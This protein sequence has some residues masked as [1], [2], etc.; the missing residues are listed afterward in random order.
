MQQSSREKLPTW[1]IYLF[2]T[3]L[4]IVFAI[5]LLSIAWNSTLEKEESLVAAHLNEYNQDVFQNFNSVSNIAESLAVF[6][7][8]NPSIDDNQFEYITQNQI[9][10]YPFV[11]SVFYAGLSVTGSNTDITS[12]TIRHI[13][14]RDHAYLNMGDNLYQIREIDQAI[15]QQHQAGALSRFS[16]SFSSAFGAIYGLFVPVMSVSG[17]DNTSDNIAG[18]IGV[19]IQPDKIAAAIGKPEN[20]SVKIFS[21]NPVLGRQIL[22]ANDLTSSKGKFVVSSVSRVNQYQFPAATIRTEIIRYIKFSDLDK[23]LVYITLIIGA[24]ITLLL[25]ALVRAKDLQ[26]RELALRN[27]LIE[28]KVNEQTQELAEAKNQAIRASQMKSEFLASMSHEIRTPLNA[29]IGMS[30]LLSETSLSEEQNKY[31]S[32]FRRA[33]NTLLALVNDILDL[34]KIEARQ[35]VLEKIPFNVTEL[36]EEVLEINALKAAEKGIELFSYVEP[37]FQANRNGDPNR[38]RQVLLNLISNSLKFTESGEIQVHVQQ[39]GHEALEIRVSDTGIGIAKDKLD[40]IFDSFTQA[41]SSTTRQYGGTGLGLAI[42]RSLIALMGGQLLVESEVGSG[43]IFIIKISLP[44]VEDTGYQDIAPALYG[45]DI[46]IMSGNPAY[47]KSIGDTINAHGGKW[48]Q[49]S[50]D[51]TDLPERFNVLLID[52]NLPGRDIYQKAQELKKGSSKMR[53]IILINPADLNRNISRI[54]QSPIDSYLVKPVKQNDLLKVLINPDIDKPHKVTQ[55]DNQ[56]T[57]TDNGSQRNILL[58]DD[59]ADNRLLI[60]AYLRKTPYQVDEAVNGEEALQLFNTKRYDLILMDM[61]MPVMDGYTATAEIRR[62]EQK[63]NLQQTPV[64]ALTAHVTR[65]EIDK[66]L[67]S[68]CTAHLAKPIK[69]SVLLET[70]DKYVNAN[71]TI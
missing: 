5:A 49:I 54:Q 46:G 41:D 71:S 21:D 11:V 40:A 9:R 59:T 51:C 70:I 57:R 10:N 48:H 13:L 50:P 3:V 12:A 1:I 22:Y 23:Q 66:C 20:L 35:L 42:S 37:G 4:G 65:E 63:K 47:L 30:D 26:A 38:L 33:G 28:Q 61:Q 7:Q 36:I 45:L 52:N 15:S 55:N 64:I 25:V 24:G 44:V 58:V 43:S 56:N 16:T 14:N 69:K 17:Q 32:V 68:G 19:L 34:S 60:N 8:S 27:V 67:S 6:V 2:I 53:I 18:I 39:S 62:Q 31:V 29:I